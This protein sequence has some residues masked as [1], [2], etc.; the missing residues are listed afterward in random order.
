MS[1]SKN[2]LRVTDFFKILMAAMGLLPGKMLISS[3]TRRH[4]ILHPLGLAQMPRECPSLPVRGRM[5]LGPATTNYKLTN[6]V[7]MSKEMC[8]SEMEAAK[9][10]PRGQYWLCRP[11]SVQGTRQGGYSGLSP[12]TIVAGLSSLGTGLY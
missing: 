5:A 7:E 11:S 3:Y 4:P 6:N 1:Q 10:Q 12:T 2:T 9:K 8:K